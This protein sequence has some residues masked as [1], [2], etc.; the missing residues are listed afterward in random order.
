MVA[1]VILAMVV[2][3]IE[4]NDGPTVDDVVVVDSV[5]DDVTCKALHCIVLYCIVLYCNT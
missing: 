2:G 5:N 3:A 1:I 4:D